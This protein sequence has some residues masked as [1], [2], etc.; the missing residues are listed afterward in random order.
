ML[1]RTFP[2]EHQI[3]TSIGT[4]MDEDKTVNYPVVVL[5][6][7][8][9]LG[10]SHHILKL[11]VG[12]LVILLRNIDARKLCNDTGL[13]IK[14]MLPKILEAEIIKGTFKEVQVFIPRIRLIDLEPPVQF[15]LMQF[16]TTVCFTMTINTLRGLMLQ[17]LGL[18]FRTPCFGYS[19]LYVAC[20]RVG[21]SAQLHICCPG[22]R[23]KSVAHKDVLGK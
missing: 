2:G 10:F 14:Q 4:V 23:A 1:A 16:P 19:Q 8:T 6:S 21:S 22:E 7:L 5:N 15:K 11:K 12:V 3:Y 13:L 9:P 17:H 18:D 20:S